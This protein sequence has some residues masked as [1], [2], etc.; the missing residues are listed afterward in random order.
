MNRQTDRERLLA[1][2]LA[3]AEPARFRENLLGET[4]RLAGY[5][6]RIRLARRAAAALAVLGLVAALAWRALVTGNTAITLQGHY[7]LVRTAPLPGSAIISTHAFP[8]EHIMTSLGK[9]SV[10][11]TT[12]DGQRPR[13][14][15]D[16]T[17]L[18]LVAPRP[19]V[20]VSLGPNSAE[21]I[22]MKP[23][24]AAPAGVN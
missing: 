18:A 20:L 11:R 4:L 5:R 17:L 9:V 8:G 24:G 3:E 22:F 15:N 1:D 2:V 6:R 12:P 21:L 13:A 10:V 23:D 7:N 19:A 16:D 14:I